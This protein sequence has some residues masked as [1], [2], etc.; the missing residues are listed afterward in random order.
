M[1]GQAKV[2]IKLDAKPNPKFAEAATAIADAP[3]EWLLRGLDH[4]S[5]FV[6]NPKTPRDE[7]RR[8]VKIIIPQMH[9]AA[10]LLIKKLPMFQGLPVSVECPDDIAIA[11]AA[12][13]RIKEYLAKAMTLPSWADV[14]HK[15]CAVVVFEAW[16]LIHGKPS[17]L[18]DQLR[19]ACREYWEVCGG[20]DG[21]DDDWRR[22]VKQA[23]ANS[24]HTWIR[25]VLAAYK[26]R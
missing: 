24:G 26:T 11:L 6:G 3:P 16:T 22:H 9:D 18:P 4:F 15:T 21:G 5:T 2:R 19:S 12:L 10:D 8:F 25:E 14:R 20:G 1:S 13:P 17:P 23:A 7:M